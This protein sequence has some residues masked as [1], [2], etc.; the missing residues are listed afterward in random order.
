[1]RMLGIAVP[2]KEMPIT[3]TTQAALAK[4][5]E[6]KYERRKER[7]NEGERKRTEATGKAR[8]A[9][10][11]HFGMERATAHEILARLVKEG[12]YP[13]RPNSV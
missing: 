9:I 5:L 3:S 8:D 6:T 1:M 4:D 10:G 11:R 12:E 2:P 13:Y 7:K